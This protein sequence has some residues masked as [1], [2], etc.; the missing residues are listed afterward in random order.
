MVKCRITGVVC[1]MSN[2]FVENCN[3]PEVKISIGFKVLLARKAA[4]KTQQE[5][6]DVINVHINTYRGKENGQIASSFSADQV[7]QLEEFLG[8]KI[9]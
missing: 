2:Y 3:L 4:K 6:A 8:T 5:C 9:M 1:R 7:S